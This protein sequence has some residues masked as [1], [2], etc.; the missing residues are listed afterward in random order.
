MLFIKPTNVLVYTW[1]ILM[2]FLV[3]YSSV[4]IMFRVA[5]Q[6]YSHIWIK[7]VDWIIEFFFF[8]DI[9]HNFILEYKDDDYEPVRDHTLIAKR[10]IFRGTFF[11]D[12]IAF[13]PWFLFFDDKL[14][15]LFRM[16]RIFR[17][18][19]V[20]GYIS[21]PKIREWFRRA[22]SGTSRQNQVVYVHT[23][24]VL[25]RVTVLAIQAIFI[26]YF[27]GCTWWIISD[28]LNSVER[29]RTF[30]KTFE[31]AESP[32]YWQCLVSCYFCLTT[33]STVGYGDYYPISNVERIFCIFLMIGGVV[34]FSFIMNNFIEIISIYDAKIGTVDRSLDL[35]NW[36]SLLTKFTNNKPLP[37]QL[38]NSMDSHFSYFWNSD[39]LANVERD[40]IYMVTLPRSLKRSLM[41]NYLFKDIFTNFR[42]FFKTFE[43]RHSKFLYD[44]SFGFMPR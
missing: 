2:L 34:F 6:D 23:C 7:V 29:S 24:T 1:T 44:V 28:R 3:L 19:K 5:Y 32:S 11:P 25:Y 17:L 27:L 30:I 40:D 4:T 35:H 38:I 15:M 39:R 42:T 36:M 16:A 21:V 9:L 33:L 10:Y 43:N 22:F 14:W 31:L 13:I 37:R 26:T 12:I 8:L 41:T 18:T 20:S